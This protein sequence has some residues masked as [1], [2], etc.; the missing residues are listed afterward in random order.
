MNKK[1]IIYSGTISP[2]GI[3]NVHKH[4][5]DLK[6]KS[7]TIVPLPPRLDL[8]NHSP[9]GFAWG[10]SCYNG[11]DDIN[12]ESCP[13]LNHVKN[14]GDLLVETTD[15]LQLISE[16]I[17]AARNAIR[18]FHTLDMNDGTTF[19]DNAARRN[20]AIKK[21]ALE[22]N[23]KKNLVANVQNVITANAKLRSI[24]TTLKDEKGMENMKNQEEL[25]Y[26]KSEITQK[27]SNL[28]AQTAT[29]KNTNLNYDGSAQLALALLADYFGNQDDVAL[30]FYQMFKRLFV[31]DLREDSEW[32]VSQRRIGLLANATA[33]FFAAEKAEIAPD[34][35]CLLPERSRRAHG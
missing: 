11:P 28:S 15:A 5:V 8:A 23:L 25:K 9:D 6:S 4:I 27:D 35:L 1:E 16:K 20:G 3:R 13:E 34:I 29:S 21:E 18:H 30:E 31:A 12:M 2:N 14:V 7:V 24:F 26:K 17:D 10:V 19:V 22:Q 33:Y 32:T